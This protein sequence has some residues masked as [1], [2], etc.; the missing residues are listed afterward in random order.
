MSDKEKTLQDVV[1]SVDDAV[2]AIESI[3]DSIDNIR[4]SVIVNVPTQ[5]VPEV[6]VTPSINVSVPPQPIPQTIIHP[7]KPVTYLFEVLKR[8]SYDNIVLAKLT[9]QE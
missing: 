1:N 2:T 3:G 4:P 7:H 9:P 8:D 5:P 6:R